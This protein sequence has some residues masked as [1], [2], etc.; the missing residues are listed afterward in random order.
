VQYGSVISKTITPTTFECWL[1]SERASGFGRYPSRRA[2]VSIR[3]F[4]SAGMYRES[5]A[6]FS[7]MDTVEAEYPLSR[8]TSRIVITAFFGI[9]RN[10]FYF[11]ASYSYR[12]VGGKRSDRG[13]V[14]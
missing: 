5:G 10:I 6:L 12:K 9:L 4:V 7:T 11:G 3:S 2:V 8:A 13:R 1:L 14:L